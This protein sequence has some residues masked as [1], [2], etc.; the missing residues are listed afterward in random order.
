MV[1]RCPY[2]SRNEGVEGV[3]IIQRMVLRC[4]YYSRNEGVEGV[5]IIQGMKVLRVSLSF[6]E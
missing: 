1:L 5:L 3:L 2:Y 6:K 4:P